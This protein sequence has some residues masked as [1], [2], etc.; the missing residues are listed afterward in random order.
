[1]SNLHLNHLSA[2]VISANGCRSLPTACRTSS[3]LAAGFP[4]MHLAF[5]SSVR[6]VPQPVVLALPVAYFRWLHGASVLLKMSS[7]PEY[8][9]E[10]RTIFSHAFAPLAFCFHLALK[11]VSVSRGAMIRHRLGPSKHLPI[12]AVVCCPPQRPMTA[13]VWLTTG[14]RAVRRFLAILPQMQLALK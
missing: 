10:R 5:A 7:V 2:K 12:I 8:R 6:H 1:M 4:S 3:A 14:V 9:A 11:H 13:S